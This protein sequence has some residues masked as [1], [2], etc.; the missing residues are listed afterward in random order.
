ME[1]S[2][3]LERLKAIRGLADDLEVAV[4]GQDRA[5]AVAHGPVVVGDERPGRHA[6]PM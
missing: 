6:R 4:G 3:E 2:G 5:D 1:R